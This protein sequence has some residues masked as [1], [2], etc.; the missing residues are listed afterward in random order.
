MNFSA[1]TARS[2]LDSTTRQDGSA[3]HAPTLRRRLAEL[4]HSSVA[5]A[6]AATP[7]LT[8]DRSLLFDLVQVEYREHLSAAEDLSPQ[9]YC[10]QFE[11]LDSNLLHSLHRLVEV[12]RFLHANPDLLQLVDEPRWP[13]VGE[14]LDGFIVQQELGRGAIARVYL[15]QELALG[16][17]DVVL[18]VTTVAH[19]EAWVQGQ[20]DHPNVMPIHAVSDPSKTSG[21]HWICM[22]LLGRITLQQ[23]VA[24][25]RSTLGDGD[26]NAAVLHEEIRVLD[27]TSSRYPDFLLNVLRQLAD[28]MA[29][30]HGKGIFHGDLK[31][32]NVLV[33]ETGKPLLIDFNLS[34]DRS[35]DQAQLGG[36]LLYMAPEQLAQIASPKD[37]FRGGTFVGTATEIFSFG[38][39]AISLVT[40]RET[41][42]TDGRVGGSLTKSVLE[43]RRQFLPES[44]RQA[45]TIHPLLAELLGMCLE[46]DPAKRPGSFAEVVRELEEITRGSRPAKVSSKPSTRAGLL[47]LVIVL[48]TVVA[49]VFLLASAGPNRSLRLAKASSERGEYEKSAEIYARLRE[50]HPEEREYVIG[51]ADSLLKAG[52][53]QS[54]CEAYASSVEAFDMPLDHAMMGYCFNLSNDYQRAIHWYRSTEQRGF[55]S[56]AVKANL[57]RCLL[58]QLNAH[59]DTELNQP[60]SSLLIAANRL[61]PGDPTLQ[62]LMIQHY[63]ALARRGVRTPNYPIEITHPVMSAMT[64]TDLVEVPA[65]LVVSGASED[66]LVRLGLPRLRVLAAK[67][68]PDNLRSALLPAEYAAYERLPGFEEAMRNLPHEANTAPATVL[69]DP[70]EYRLVPVSPVGQ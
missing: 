31:P 68:G 26:S 59:Y 30:V 65:Y 21:L 19:H 33:D 12:E 14:K 56:L 62:G 47:A 54:A 2:L 16:R 6:L 38:Q 50:R 36:T 13:R 64:D 42:A 57:A 10:D 53:P 70:R 9:E 20:L 22:P 17:R 28:A 66:D 44:L 18:K 63:L 15:C 55:T 3:D 23:V 7:E 61:H 52:D 43:Q 37:G 1:S 46:E 41:Y 11:D 58:L 5:S 25:R 4:G 49:G 45:D 8:G 67:I 48:V 24:H 34:S 32:S 39:L 27:L 29:Y 40:G 51:Q 60:I 69:Y 35:I